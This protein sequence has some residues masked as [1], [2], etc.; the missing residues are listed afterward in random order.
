MGRSKRTGELVED[1][2][3][4]ADLDAAWTWRCRPWISAIFC[5]LAGCGSIA[6]GTIVNMHPYEM[7]YWFRSFF[8]GIGIINAL[9]AFF[10]PKTVLAVASDK[11]TLYR[12]VGPW[13]GIR[14]KT[15]SIPLDSVAGIVHRW[16]YLFT[17]H[18]KSGAMHRMFVQTSEGKEYDIFPIDQL[19]GFPARCGRSLAEFL[20]VE[21]RLDE[22]KT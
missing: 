10:L 9:R 17:K 11:K 3:T 4:V 6:V 8:I 5:L 14:S 12:T 16:R 18:E 2:W 20:H 22:D 7:N 21:F 15:Y 19:P 13:I 1:A